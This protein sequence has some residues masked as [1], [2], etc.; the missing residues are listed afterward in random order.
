MTSAKL[1]AVI[2][3]ESN[4]VLGVLRGLLADARRKSGGSVGEREHIAHLESKIEG[5]NL[6]RERVRIAVAEAFAHE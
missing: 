4:E 2:T 3:A 6:C 5:V 1:Q